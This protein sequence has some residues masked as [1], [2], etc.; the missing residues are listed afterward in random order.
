MLEIARYE[1]ER[2]LRG[3]VALAVGIGVLSLA[4]I[5]FFPS[6]A[7]A[8]IDELV[9]AYPPAMQEA[10]GIQ[11]LGT[12]E[13]FLAVEI[14]QFMWLLLLGLY[15]A[16]AAAN[17]VAEDVERDRMDLVLS[18][19]VSRGRVVL[20]TFAALAV[21]VLVLNAIVP[22][23]VYGGVVAV[24]ESI[25]VQDLAMVHLLSIPYL[26][27][28]TAIGLVLSVTVSR[29]TV[30]NRLAIAVVFVLFLIESIT[31]GTDDYGW[32]GNGSPTHY[33]DPTEILVESTYDLTGAAIL[34]I[35]TAVLVL[36][37]RALFSRG[38][39]GA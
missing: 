16:Y 18:L 26:L 8:D 33:Y 10:F 36:I 5:G 1:A 25:S 14:Y 31:V 12:I 3:T 28:C 23:A 17:S 27:A 2:R 30:A 32:I 39:I 22:V 4:F 35:A 9:E 37:A 19:P 29:A 20:E 34:L 11:T 7:D 13:G 24:G 15:V 21:P 6:F 38:D